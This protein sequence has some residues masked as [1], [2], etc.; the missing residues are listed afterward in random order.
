MRWSHRIIFSSYPVEQRRRGSLMRTRMVSMQTSQVALITHITHRFRK[1]IDLRSITINGWNPYYHSCDGSPFLAVSRNGYWWIRTTAHIQRILLQQW[2]VRYRGFWSQLGGLACS[3][4]EPE[5]TSRTV[6]VYDEAMKNWTCH[7]R[8][9]PIRCAGFLDYKF[10]ILSRWTMTGR[11]AD[12]NLNDLNVNL[13]GCL[14]STHHTPVQE[15][16]WASTQTNQWL[17]SL[18]IINL[19]VTARDVWWRVLPEKPLTTH[20]WFGL[21]LISTP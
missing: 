7:W 6:W 12:E 9:P 3:G 15:G 14:N 13:L 4:S 2:A 17:K 21:R 16:H 10:L 11:T 19:R 5:F 20:N 1:V 18:S 8:N